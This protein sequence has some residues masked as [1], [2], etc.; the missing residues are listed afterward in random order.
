[1]WK[2]ENTDS[3]ILHG[4]F[5]CCTWQLNPRVQH[6]IRSTGV[7]LFFESGGAHGPNTLYPTYLGRTIPHSGNEKLSKI[8]WENTFIREKEIK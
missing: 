6:L 1:M 8:T 7:L 4:S 5:S 2:N 3:G